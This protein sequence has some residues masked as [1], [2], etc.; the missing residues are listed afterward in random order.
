M[1]SPDSGVLS[2]SD[3]LL[4]LDEFGSPLNPLIGATRYT[5]IKRLKHVI[6][7][8]S[9]S[10]CNNERLRRLS[11]Y[12]SGDEDSDVE[13][14][15][16]PYST[17]R[18]ISSRVQIPN[19]PKNSPLMPPSSSPVYNSYS[20]LGSTIDRLVPV[21]SGNRGFAASSPP[22]ITDNEM[23]LEQRTAFSPDSMRI[24]HR[25][26]TNQIKGYRSSRGQCDNFR[27]EDDFETGSDSDGPGSV[28]CKRNLPDYTAG[29]LKQNN[30]SVSPQTVLSESGVKIALART[31][32]NICSD[33][34]YSKP[35]KN[36]AYHIEHTSIASTGHG[37][38]PLTTES[39]VER[40]HQAANGKLA[41]N[42]LN[43]LVKLF[44]PLMKSL[45]LEIGK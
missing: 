11:R 28:T 14:K 3:L 25:S 24:R 33:S 36:E 19:E 18:K 21:Q 44:H 7:S 39:I 40:E 29:D 34:S 23:S 20:R 1:A 12:S 10:N 32:P 17:D 9:S 2:Y 22:V 5:L 41:E 30:I 8:K 4:K 26:S 13:Q 35:P 15:V 27:I 43:L 16:S 6:Q 31:K 45:S 42:R 37:S 38:P